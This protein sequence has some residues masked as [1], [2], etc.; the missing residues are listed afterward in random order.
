MHRTITILHEYRTLY[1]RFQPSRRAVFSGCF[2]TGNATKRPT[3]PG[4]EPDGNP[5][6]LRHAAYFSLSGER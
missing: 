2:W 3:W 4:A 1:R 5:S 6:A